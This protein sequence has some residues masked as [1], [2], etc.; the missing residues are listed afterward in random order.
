MERPGSRWEGSCK[1]DVTET[2][3]GDMGWVRLAQV[4]DQRQVLVN[5]A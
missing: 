4:R 1:A 2:G 3:Y 5:T